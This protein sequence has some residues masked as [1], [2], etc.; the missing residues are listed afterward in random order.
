MR[1]RTFE[2]YFFRKLILIGNLS[3]LLILLKKTLFVF[4]PT[5]NLRLE[6]FTTRQSNNISTVNN[7]LIRDIS[8]TGN[9]S[10]LF[11]NTALS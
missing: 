6:C 7:C 1:F 3:F 2:T 5:F 11:I 9:G 10:A 4:T 8:S